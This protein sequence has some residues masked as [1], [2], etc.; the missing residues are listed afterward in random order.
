MTQI[1]VYFLNQR[2]YTLFILREIFQ[3]FF[4]PINPQKDIMKGWSLIPY[5][6]G[7]FFLLITKTNLNLGLLEVSYRLQSIGPHFI[8]AETALQFG[9][10]VVGS[11]LPSLH[12][13]GS[14]L[15]SLHV[16]GSHLPPLKVTVSHF[17]IEQLVVLHEEIIKSE[18]L[19][20][21]T[22][23]GLV[24]ISFDSIE[25]AFLLF[26]LLFWE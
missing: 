15:P 6:A 9:L 18:L 3:D 20:H 1:Y 22:F 11:H 7:N 21:F 17:I 4:F 26:W 19:Q 16:V 13:V 2:I 25:S 5:V 10:Q 23:E 24:E 14:H 12:V 8:S